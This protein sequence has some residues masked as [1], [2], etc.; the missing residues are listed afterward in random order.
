[1]VLNFA[2]I[3]M[4]QWRW[5]RDLNLKCCR[6]V[7]RNICWRCNFSSDVVMV[8]HVDTRHP[9]RGGDG[10][11]RVRSTLAGTTEEGLCRRGGQKNLH[12][13]LKSEESAEHTQDRMRNWGPILN[14]CVCVCALKSEIHSNYPSAGPIW[15]L[16][17]V[18]QLSVTPEQLQSFIQT[19]YAWGRFNASVNFLLAS[20][21][22]SRIILSE[23]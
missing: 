21:I 5:H 20:F 12:A 13:R 15:D 8:A 7:T 16:H 22:C 1:M 4:A 23:S 6:K 19:S 2:E 17:T 11:E 14:R 9:C 3:F 10:W 18:T